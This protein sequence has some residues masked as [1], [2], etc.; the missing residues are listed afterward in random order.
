VASPLL[1]CFQFY[2]AQP[3]LLTGAVAVTVIAHGSGPFLQ[4]AIGL[5]VHD[6]ELGRSVVPLPGG[7]TDASVAW[8][9]FTVLALGALARGVVQ[10]LA[11]VL[12]TVLGQR[13]LHALRDRVLVQVQRLDLGYHQRHGSGE[14]ITRTTRDSDKVRDAVVG[15]W[16]TLLELA[17]MVG[18]AL[19]LLACYH[20]L[21]ALVPTLLTIGAIIIFVK[22]TDRMVALDRAAGD[23]YDQVTQDLAEGINGIR[24][25]KAFALEPAR[26]ARFAT[27]VNGFAE[28]MRTVLAFS[29]L[30]MPP[31]QL[32]A[33]A[34]QVW[35]LA[36]GAW[37]VAEGELS[38]G[39]LIA[40]VMAIQGMVFRVEGIGRML[41]V[42][43]DAR[44]SSARI[45]DLLDAVP[46]VADGAGAVPT[47][48]L[49]LRLDGVRVAS[50][51]A[52][53]LDGVDL[54]VA[55]GE[56][57]A[58]VGATGGGKSTL[59]SLLPRLRDPDAGRVLVGS[60]AAGWHDLRTLRL[61]ELRRRVQV[62]YQDS[63]LFSDSLS[64]NLRLAAPQADDD[65][66]RAALHLAAADD[67]L[68]LLTD[69]LAGRI[70][71]RGATLSGGQRQRVCLARALLAKPAV[72]CLDD[73]TSAL[74]AVTERRILDGFRA[75][76]QHTATLII[77]SKL[78][79]I[80]L[81]DRVLLLHQ[82]RIAI[83]GRHG[84]LVRESALY[85]DLL[86]LDDEAAA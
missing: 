81:A 38:K 86:G 11:T 18:G 54:T 3:A 59:A 27:Q 58:L 6:L 64:A 8:F 32:L 45:W 13:L 7:G 24:V 62:V 12:A 63:F 36:C 26:I 16:R 5:A 78:S 75:G 28:L 72:L 56:V 20:W 31:P 80:L 30:R 49:G 22:Q 42:F 43:A 25:I 34:G 39:Y 23:A 50:S 15:G 17:L 40:A 10:Y 76:Q 35:V 52:S 48:A 70:G 65:E 33:A 71:E 85:R 9:W 44:S 68:A 73:A 19:I 69:G 79:T 84:D 46:A 61:A 51:G 29:A 67:V 4:H 2:R 77:A 57:V 83:S 66:L 14:I 74:D 37:L 21:L 60:D 82:G 47:G 53:V 41:Q 55:P 1:R